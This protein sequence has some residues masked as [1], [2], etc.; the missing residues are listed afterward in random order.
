MKRPHCKTCKFWT[1]HTDKFSTPTRGDCAS[2][3]FH[4]ANTEGKPTPTQ[5]HYW[6]YEGYM[7]GFDT[8]EDFGCI[9]WAA[10]S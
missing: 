5:L 2:T 6:D 8:G 7:C 1:R 9:H 10:K 3:G 4:D